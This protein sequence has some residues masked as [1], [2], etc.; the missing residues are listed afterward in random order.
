MWGY[1][2][3]RKPPYSTKREVWTRQTISAGSSED[4]AVARLHGM[5]LHSVT[6]ACRIFTFGNDMEDMYVKYGSLHI[7]LNSVAHLVHITIAWLNMGGR[8]IDDL[9]LHPRKKTMT[10][11]ILPSS[12]FLNIWPIPIWQ[13]KHQ[14]SAT[15][16][17]WESFTNTTPQSLQNCLIVISRMVIFSG[18]VAMNPGSL[19][20]LSDL[21]SGNLVHSYWKWL[22]TKLNFSMVL[23]VYQREPFVKANQVLPF[24]ESGTLTSHK[25]HACLRICIDQRY[26]SN[27]SANRWLGNS[28]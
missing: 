11:I 14:L 7:Y 9:W 17:S 23:L 1:P 8:K 21:S 2:Y 4:K 27:K 10:D 3:S 25:W 18:K 16:S 28:K 12:P 5:L 13:T 20:Y 22:F 26:T 24:P 15:A 19:E 6:G